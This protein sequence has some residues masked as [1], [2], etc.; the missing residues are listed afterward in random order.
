MLGDDDPELRRH[1]SG[2]LSHADAI[3]IVER[4][5]DAPEDLKC[6]IF[7]A[8]SDNRWRCRDIS[9]TQDVLGCEPQGGADVRDIEDKGRQ[10]QVNMTT[11]RNHSTHP[12]PSLSPSKR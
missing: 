8:A 6:D 12:M 5:N 3:Q 1:Y 11:R 7:E 4:C 9:H 2:Y 10:H